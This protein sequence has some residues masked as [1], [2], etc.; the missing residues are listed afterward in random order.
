MSARRRDLERRSR[1]N[2]EI[3]MN[4]WTTVTLSAVAAAA[5]TV[6]CL[7]RG[8]SSA[9]GASE[10]VAS[11]AEPRPRPIPTPPTPHPSPVPHPGPNPPPPPPGPDGRA[12]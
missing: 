6:P 3:V 4:R 5:L 11:H 1:S 2:K 8:A 7:A 9:A 12:V 10:V